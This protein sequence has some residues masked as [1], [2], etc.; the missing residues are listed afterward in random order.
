MSLVDLDEIAAQ[1]KTAGVPEAT[2]SRLIECLAIA[3]GGS[4]S[5]FRAAPFILGRLVQR[6]EVD[7]VAVIPP[8]VRDSVGLDYSKASSK[9]EAAKAEHGPDSLAHR[10]AKQI[11]DDYT[12]LAAAETAQILDPEPS[13]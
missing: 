1:L 6:F 7:A 5:A 12:E 11:L 8:N 9:I 3:L 13:T 2:D 10:V 4:E